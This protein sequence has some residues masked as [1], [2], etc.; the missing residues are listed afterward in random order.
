MSG[1]E[2]NKIIA[3]IIVAILVIV[4]IS[5][6]AD[7]IMNIN[8]DEKKDVAYKIDLP[9]PNS[10]KATATA[11]IETAIDPISALLMNSSIE[12]GEKIYKKCGSCHNYEKGGG[13][14]VGPNLWNIVNRSKA[15]MDGFAYSDALAKSGGVWSYEELAAFVY[16]PKEY[17]IGTKMNFA[18]LKK[19]EDR[20]DLVL[21]LRDQSDNP[22]PLP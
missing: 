7:I 19:A 13:N 4:I 11:Q 2:V 18:G 21:F 16:K 3:S 1:L 22:A 20:A 10:S 8:L 17:I 12:R 5:Y 6:A 15:S 14:K 9:E